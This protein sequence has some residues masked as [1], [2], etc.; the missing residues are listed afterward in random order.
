[1]RKGHLCLLYSNQ[2]KRDWNI[3]HME[4]TDF[5]GTNGPKQLTI[6]QSQTN[7][8]GSITVID[9]WETQFVAPTG[10][11]CLHGVYRE[12]GYHKCSELLPPNHWIAN[13]EWK[14]IFEA[15]SGSVYVD[16]PRVI[17]VSHSH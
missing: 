4:M 5:L 2:S 9:G 1:M 15:L 10:S 12:Y 14:A 6:L 3:E 8:G 16:F 7:F 11:H 17:A 13:F